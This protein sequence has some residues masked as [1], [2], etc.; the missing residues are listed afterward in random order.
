[1]Q[2]HVTVVKPQNV[3]VLHSH[4]H[5]C[6]F[7][8]LCGLLQRQ[9]NTRTQPVHMAK[10][11]KWCAP[12]LL[13]FSPAASISVLK[14]PSLFAAS[15]RAPTCEVRPWGTAPCLLQLPPACPLLPAKLLPAATALLAHSCAA[16]ARSA[17]LG[18]LG[19]VRALMLLGSGLLWL[20]FGSRAAR[21]SA[22]RRSRS[23]RMDD[24]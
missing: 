5:L 12:L 4:A 21:T 7:I 14:L 24:G 13:G 8:C 20:R 3:S 19:P 2:G 15:P 10:S 9:A 23:S 18:R 17:E 11:S 1:M 22:A 16:A 6:R